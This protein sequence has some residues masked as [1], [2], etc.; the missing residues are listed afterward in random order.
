MSEHDVNPE[1]IQREATKAAELEK[2]I[3]EMRHERERQIAE[4][5][6]NVDKLN[7]ALVTLT[8]DVA[9]LVGD[10]KTQRERMNSQ[11]KL[12]A[13]G[14]RQMELVLE[15]QKA[16]LARHTR[17]EFEKKEAIAKVEAERSSAA[18]TLEQQRKDRV[19][20][21]MDTVWKVIQWAAIL[22]LGSILNAVWIQY[23]RK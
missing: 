15:W 21:I 4:T 5:N 20:P 6:R 19:R 11:D 23:F 13:Q 22:A 8:K 7:S 3:Q 18:T 17:E 16:E 2:E 10:E 14:A 12:I 9:E 1:C